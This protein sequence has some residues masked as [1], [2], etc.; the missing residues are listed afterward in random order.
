[1]NLVLRETAMIVR[2]VYRWQESRSRKSS[3]RISKFSR[4]IMKGQSKILFR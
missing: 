2:Q 3:V 1:M 4:E